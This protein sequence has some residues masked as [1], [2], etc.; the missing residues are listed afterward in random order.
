MVIGLPSFRDPG[1][2]RLSR[3]L[4]QPLRK[5]NVMDVRAER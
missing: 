1:E 2:L 5:G 4:L 3:M